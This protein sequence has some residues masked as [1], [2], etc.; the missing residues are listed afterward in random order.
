MVVLLLSDILNFTFQNGI[1]KCKNF[2]IGFF[3]EL[4]NFE[5]KNFT[6]QNVILFCILQQRTLFL[7]AQCLIKKTKSKLL[8]N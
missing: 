6:F 1:L 5:Q 8:V 7:V 2:L 3:D 4:G